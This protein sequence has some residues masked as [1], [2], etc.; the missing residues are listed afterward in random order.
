MDYSMLGFPV[1]H[2]LP[3]FAQIHVSDAIQPSHPL[4][5]PSSPAF[6]LSQHQ[7]KSWT[8]KKAKCQRIDA[9]ELRYWRRLLESLGLQGDQTSQF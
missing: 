7:S 9:F 2:S 4:S 5:S 8:I 3:E 6:N 1:L